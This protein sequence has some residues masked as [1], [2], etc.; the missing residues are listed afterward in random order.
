MNEGEIAVDLWSFEGGGEWEGGDSGVAAGGDGGIGLVDEVFIGPVLQA[1]HSRLPCR[2][3]ALSMS[4]S[5]HFATPSIMGASDAPS[6]DVV[7]QALAS[8]RK[9]LGMEIEIGRAHV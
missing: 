1:R 6:G 8:M 9:H 5:L 4:S 3:E 2:L 7:R